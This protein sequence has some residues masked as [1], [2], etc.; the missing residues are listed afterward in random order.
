[1]QLTRVSITNYRGIHQM[2]VPLSRFACLIGR[3]NAGKSTA[4]Q[5]VSLFFTGTKLPRGD[6]FDETKP[7][8][9]AITLS[10]ISQL[11]LSRLAPEHRDRIA[12]VAVDG[13]LTL[14]RF[15]ETDGKSRFRY[16]GLVPKESRFH[17][18]EISALVKGKKGAGL[19]T[20]VTG[21]FPEL[22]GK[23]DSSATITNARDAIQEF[24]RSLPADQKE[25]RDADLPTGID[26]SIKG[27]L[28]EP[29]YIPAVKNLSDDIKTSQ[30]TPF[31]RILGILMDA[32]E[33]KL[34]NIATLFKE[35]SEK[36]NRTVLSDGT[37][38]D[39]RLDEV[40]LI[41]STVQDFVRESFAG[42]SL[43]IK[44]PPP[45]L[46]TLLSSAQI[47][48]DDGVTGPIDSKGDG[49]RR[50]VVF[51]VL[52]SYVALHQPGAIAGVAQDGPSDRHV[53]LFGSI[54]V[55]YG[56]RLNPPQW[57]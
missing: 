55:S 44:V 6:F 18:S 16:A 25:E 46:R 1:M 40:K 41:E 7:I 34:G 19:V 10:G 15:Y 26:E 27:F 51:A 35:L 54:W 50:A 33:P 31:G 14:V 57:K 3:N 56:Y 45:E 8:R 42:V 5:A 48:V 49:L 24:A 39:N 21:Q 11:D 9:I 2:D 28:P 4:L 13:N 36:F 23:L 47:L 20:A 53:L 22:K 29:I 43:E 32:V 52:R 37:I 12:A 38:I 17:D 30:A